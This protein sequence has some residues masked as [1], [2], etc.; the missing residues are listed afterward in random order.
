MTLVEISYDAAKNERNI[1]ERG[2]SFDLA[3]AFAFE[4]ALFRIDERRDYSEVRIQALGFVG[5]R[6]HM[7]VFCETDDSIRIISFRKANAREVKK[8]EETT[9]S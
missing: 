9:K 4:T 6:L 3:R 2:L 8:Y 1:T 5:E 7:L